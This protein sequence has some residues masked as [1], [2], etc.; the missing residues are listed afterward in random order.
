MRPH[1]GRCS[2]RS[3][4]VG[5]TSSSSSATCPGTVSTATSPSPTI[6]HIEQLYASPMARALYCSVDPDLYQPLN[7][8]KNWDLTYLGT[9][10]ADRQA[11]LERLLIEPA[12]RV[13]Q[14]KFCVAGPQYPQSIDWP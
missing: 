7:V 8:P 14:L 6:E 12:R 13:P 4:G 5:T 9:Y 11:A 3:P 2:R 1:T 10:S